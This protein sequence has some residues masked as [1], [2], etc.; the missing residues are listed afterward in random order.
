VTQEF[1]STPEL[2]ESGKG[3]RFVHLPTHQD[4]FYDVRRVE[5]EEEVTLQTGNRFY[6]CML[7]EGAQILLKSGDAEVC[8]NYA[9]TFVIPAAAGTFQLINKSG[10]TARV[11]QAF[12]K[13][14]F[15]I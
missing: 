9:E 7:V 15:K 1:I 3:Y 4:H 14:T 12:V 13:E 11:V 6:V 8:F 2:I 5:F 10:G